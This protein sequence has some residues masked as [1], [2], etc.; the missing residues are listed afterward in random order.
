M[1]LYAVKLLKYSGRKYP[2]HADNS[3]QQNKFFRRD[4]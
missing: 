1:D 4:I 2:E 3:W